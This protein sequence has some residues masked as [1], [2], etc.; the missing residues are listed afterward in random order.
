MYH[1]IVKAIARKNF[2]KVNTKRYD[3]ILASCDSKNRHRFGGSHALGG[4]RSDREAL[5]RWFERLGRVMPTLQLSVTDVWVK[6]W[7][8]DT[9]AIVRWTGAATLAD[10]SPYRNHGVHLIR[11]RWGKVV[12]IDANEDSQ[13]V[14]RGLAAQAASGIAEAEAGPIES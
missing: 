8:N 9:V 2:E 12:E 7:P 11:M 10:G 6:G 5:K 14:A 4:T 1:T 3:S 13:A